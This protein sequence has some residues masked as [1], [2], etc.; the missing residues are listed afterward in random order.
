MSP[1]G[2]PHREVVVVPKTGTGGLEGISGTAHIDVGPGG[3]HSLLLE[4]E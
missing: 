4:L 2:G 1:E 3:E